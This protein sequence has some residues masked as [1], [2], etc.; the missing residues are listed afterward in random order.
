MRWQGCICAAPVPQFLVLPPLHTHAYHVYYSCIPHIVYIVYYLSIPCILLAHTIFSTPNPCISFIVYIVYY[1]CIPYVLLAHT[2][3][4]TPNLC[5]PY[6]LLAHTMCTTPN[7]CIPWYSIHCIL[8]AHTKPV[9]TIC[10]IPCMGMGIPMHAIYTS[11]NHTK[12]HTTLPSLHT[13]LLNINN[14]HH[15]CLVLL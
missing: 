7:S 4:T 2:I 5:L 13:S 8:L 6:V 3:C 12:L 9:H 10:I 1:P 11:T 14:I 15:C